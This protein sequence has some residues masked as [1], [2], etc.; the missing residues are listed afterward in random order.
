M[1]VARAKT[2]AVDSA[3]WLTTSFH[4]LCWFGDT[5]A[6][7]YDQLFCLVRAVQ[8]GDCDNRLADENRLMPASESSYQHRRAHDRH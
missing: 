4:G 7:E 5:L 6:Y 2:I 1:W 3:F 8:V